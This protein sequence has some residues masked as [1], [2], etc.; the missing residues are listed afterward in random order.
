MAKSIKLVENVDLWIN[1][2]EVE[3]KNG[4]FDTYFTFLEKEDSKDVFTKVKIGRKAIDGCKEL[5]KTRS[6]KIRIN[7]KFNIFLFDC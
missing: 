7:C 4:K 2:R 3:G 1:Y 5:P 6:F